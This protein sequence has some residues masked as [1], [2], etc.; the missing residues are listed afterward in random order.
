MKQLITLICL[1]GIITFS[2]AQSKKGSIVSFSIF[3][4][5]NTELQLLNNKEQAA[6]SERIIKETVA[7]LKNK[8]VLD[9]VYMGSDTKVIIKTNT[10]RLSGVKRLKGK[11]EEAIA[12]ADLVFKIKCDITFDETTAGFI[13]GIPTSRASLYLAIGVFD[14]QGKYLYQYKGK[15]KSD[16]IT[17]GREPEN[18]L[19]MTVTDF[20]IGYLQTLEELNK[21]D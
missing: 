2:S 20:G 4:A 21:E 15:N 14:A 6:F 12:G 5:Q 16:F 17:I 3:G 19:K 11:E 10:N 7:Y 13:V 8:F 1:L 9:T 18:E